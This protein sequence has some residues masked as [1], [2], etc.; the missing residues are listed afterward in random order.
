MKPFLFFIGHTFIGNNRMSQRI[1][2]RGLILSFFIVVLFFTAGHAAETIPTGQSPKADTI[3]TGQ[4][5][6]SSVGEDGIQADVFGEKGGIFHPFLVVRE[7]WTDNLFETHYDPKSDWITTVA[8]GLWVAVPSNREKLLSMSTTPTASGGLQLSR[9][10]PEAVRRYQAYAMY[11]PEVVIYADHSDHNHF[12]HNAQAM[13]QYNFNNG[14]SF[15]IIDIFNDREDI[16]GD[17]RTDTLYRYQSNLVDFLT[18]YDPSEKLTLRFGYS[19]FYLDYDE[20]INR[21]RDRMDNAFDFYAFYKIKPKTSVFAQYTHAFIDY[22]ASDDY[23][24][25]ESRYYLGI[26]WEMTAKSTGRFKVGYMEKE[27]DNSDVQDEDGFSFELQAQHNFSA[28]RAIQFNG[29][30]R[31]NES[32]VA[33]ASSFYSTGVDIGL[34]QKFTEKTSAT[35][36][37]T[38][39]QHE[40]NGLDRDD[41]YFRIGPAVRWEPREWIFLDLGYYWTDLDSNIQF[42]D[43]TSHTVILRLTLAL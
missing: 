31:F 15:D 42:Y 40:Y 34:M 3:P 27:F 7:E 36:N 25:E 32:D 9:I 37:L 5:K 6:G 43:F 10:K 39:E 8:P 33:G 11:S 24:N 1:C 13:F 18:T 12:N 29:F 17:G 30:R 2:T 35:L 21:Y 4:P 20:D 28:K 23:N 22:D 38:Y 19:N 26:N 14:L 41:D 16:S